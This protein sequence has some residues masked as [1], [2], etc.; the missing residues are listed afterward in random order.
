VSIDLH[1]ARDDEAQRVWPLAKRARLF[2][3]FTEFET[4]RTEG[5]WRLQISDRGECAV[6]ERWRNHLDIVA[7]RGAWC[8]PKHVPALVDRLMQV[9]RDQGMARLLSPLVAEEVA[10]AYHAAGMRMFEEIVVLRRVRGR[11]RPRPASLPAGVHIRPPLPADLGALLGVDSAC[12][13]DFWRYDTDRLARHFVEDRL[14]VAEEDGAVIGYTLATVIGDS[15]TLG[16]LAVVPDARGR[17]VGAAL[18]A[19]ALGYLERTGAATVSLCTQRDNAV[20]RALYA[21][22]GLRELPGKLCFLVRDVSDR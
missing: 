5:P 11:Q 12:F 22:A 9:V 2:G 10:P 15:A 8:P 6:L 4:F 17:G 3:S 20:S 18:L 1:P 19:E 14:M 7:M 13:D 21:A 16:R